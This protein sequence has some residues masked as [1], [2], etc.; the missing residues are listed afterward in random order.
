[1]SQNLLDSSYAEAERKRH[2]KRDV[3]CVILRNQEGKYLF[4]RTYKFPD[5]WGWLGGGREPEDASLAATAVRELR[6]ESGMILS[7]A[8]LQL[9]F[10]A[11]F[12]FGEGTIQFFLANSPENRVFQM[13]HEIA[14]YRW[15]ALEEAETLPMYPASR[16]CFTQLKDR[17]SSL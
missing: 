16:A 11:P 9:F 10:Q 17:V 3:A 13:N 12:D 1:M 15:L 2:P 5:V 8:E 14:E 6:E 7:E 4:I